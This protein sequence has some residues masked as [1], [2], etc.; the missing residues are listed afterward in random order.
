MA[1]ANDFKHNDVVAC[2]TAQRKIA[3]LHAAMER[4]V[5]PNL[6]AIE[7]EVSKQIK[8][9]WKR[10]RVWRAISVDNFIDSPDESTLA[11]YK[12]LMPTDVEIATAAKEGRI[13][14]K[15]EVIEIEDTTDK[16]TEPAEGITNSEVFALCDCLISACRVKG[17]GNSLAAAHKLFKIKGELHER[18]R[19]SL[20]Q[21]DLS[22]FLLCSFR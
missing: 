2:G 16:E 15:V 22:S 1:A 20:K 9:L 18:E 7:E 17:I 8:E 5:D 4:P 19:A 14:A 21:T 6:L 10:N 13:D 11:L 12:T 3:S